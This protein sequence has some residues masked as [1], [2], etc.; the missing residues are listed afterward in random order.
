MHKGHTLI[1]LM[2]VLALVGILAVMVTPVASRI[3]DW[4]AADG[5]AHDVT[6][7]LAVAR[8]AAV[9]LGQTSRLRISPDSLSID[10]R[11]SGGW[12]PWRRLPGPGKRG[13]ALQVS[14]PEVVFSPLGSGWGASNTMV[15]LSRGAATERITTSRV[16]R[17]KRW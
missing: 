5:A 3:L 16:G 6:L 4:V 13:V 9:S 17:V 15:T 1:E 12:A 2:I 10:L 14:N 7:A 8:E 11:D